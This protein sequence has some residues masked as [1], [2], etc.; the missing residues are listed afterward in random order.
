M[1][2]EVSHKRSRE[3]KQKRKKKKKVKEPFGALDSWPRIGAG[4]ASL[5]D[6]AGE[7]VHTA[8]PNVILPGSIAQDGTQFLSIIRQ[9]RP[10]IQGVRSES[11]GEAIAT[12]VF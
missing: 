6:A 5:S 4:V 2:I 10:M 1:T 9:G 12:R 7:G 8:K 3:E 11:R